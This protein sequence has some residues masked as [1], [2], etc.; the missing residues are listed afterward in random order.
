MKV[1]VNDCG[2]K[3]MLSPV[4]VLPGLFACIRGKQVSR[5]SLCAH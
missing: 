4:N 3:S 1:L 2:S 5:T